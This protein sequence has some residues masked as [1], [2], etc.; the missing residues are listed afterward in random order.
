MKIVEG[1][2]IPPANG[3]YSTCIEHAG[4]LYLSG[5]LPLL[6]GTKDCPE[7]I[8]E[9]TLL[10]LNKIESIVEAAGSEKNKIINVRLY[11]SDIH[12]WDNVN[13]VYSEFFGSHKPVRA[14]IPTRE[15]HYGCLIEAEATAAI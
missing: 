8:E 13:K 15:L 9:Q 1:Q 10:V 11:I 5:Q 14:V 6:P 2:G 4:V 7:S 3:H 12:L